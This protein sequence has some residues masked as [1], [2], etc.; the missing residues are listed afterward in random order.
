LSKVRIYW[1]LQITGWFFYAAGSYF[2][3]ISAGNINFLTYSTNFFEAFL[4][5]LASH[6]L[7]YIITRNA[8]LQM[9][10]LKVLWRIIITIL[11][12][13]IP[14]YPL[15]LLYGNLVGISFSLD[16]FDLG[17]ILNYFFFLFIWSVFYFSYHYFIRYS[18]SLKYEATMREIEL[19]HLKSQMNPHFIFNALNSIRALV[20]EN[21]I[22]SKNAI[23][24]L[25][26]I[27]RNSFMGEKRKLTKFEEELETVK[28]YLALESTRFEERL[29]TKF[30]IHPDSYEYL[31]PPFMLQTL[32][33]NG[34]KHGIGSLKEGGSIKLSTFVE[35]NLMHI[36]IRNS[37]QFKAVNNKNG[38]GLGLK[39]TKKRL[40][41][42]YGDNSSFKI[43]NENDQTVLA[44]VTIPI[45]KSYESYNN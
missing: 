36:Q 6:F 37:G 12:L 25:S 45:I 28:D 31:V 14:V 24:Q 4:L 43:F 26:N 29:T 13:S 18:E 44:V 41:L 9:P 19:Q 34:I 15:K 38:A 20:D 3:F 22:Q 17:H 10:L 16:A 23:T 32:V 2:P 40:K 21:P 7:R 30:D 1:S 27:L 33:E 39:N 8:W 11:V 42:I 35:D 5:F